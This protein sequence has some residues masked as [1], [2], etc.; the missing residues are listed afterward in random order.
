[1]KLP[2]NTSYLFIMA[3]NIYDEPEFFEGYSA[4]PRS[5][6]GLSPL[7]APEWPILSSYIPPLQDKSFLDLGCGFGWY[8]RWAADQGASI[9]HGIDISSKML[10]VAK[11]ATKDHSVIE[12]QQADLEKLRL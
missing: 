9:V 11:Q 12:Y 8:C 10:E 2:V 3:Q 1:M 5:Q 6:H 7:G 4:L